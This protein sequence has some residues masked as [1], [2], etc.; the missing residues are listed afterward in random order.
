MGRGHEVR[1]GCSERPAEAFRRAAE[2]GEGVKVPIDEIIDR[3]PKPVSQLKAVV[4]PTEVV[5]PEA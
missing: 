3:Q 4:A 1:G 5:T 2:R